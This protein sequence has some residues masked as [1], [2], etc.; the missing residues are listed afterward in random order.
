VMFR[1]LAIAGRAFHHRGA[2][3]LWLDGL[4]LVC[5][6][7]TAGFWATGLC[8]ENRCF[9]LDRNINGCSLVVVRR[10]SARKPKGF[11]AFFCPEPVGYLPFLDPLRVV[12]I[13]GTGLH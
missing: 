13:R 7:D 9:L 10:P 12:Q 2:G 1:D 6:K 4:H 8:S 5:V 11:R 3:S